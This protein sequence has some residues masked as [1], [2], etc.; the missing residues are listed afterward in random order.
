M[1]K[2]IDVFSYNVFDQSGEKLLAVCDDDILDKTFSSED[3]EITVSDFYRGRKCS[4]EE[5]VK[6]A[7]KAT[8]INAVGN[9]IVNLLIENNM[10][11]KPAVLKIG[12]VMH[13]QVVALE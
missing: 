4:K 2:G 3:I 5:I 1:K 13:A 6:I 8:I 10:V 11:N 7:K 9:K 12:G